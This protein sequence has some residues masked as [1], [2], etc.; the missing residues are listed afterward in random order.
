MEK[1]TTYYWEKV[2]ILHFTDDYSLNEKMEIA[3]AKLSKDE[4]NHFE[5]LLK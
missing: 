5:E 2:A 3:E 4:L 1:T